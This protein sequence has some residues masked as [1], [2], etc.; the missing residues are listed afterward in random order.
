MRTLGKTTMLRTD[1][2]QPTEELAILKER[3]WTNP[4]VA[5][6]LGMV[7]GSYRRRR[8]KGTL[9]DE[10]RAILRDQVA[11]GI[12]YQRGGAYNP[13]SVINQGVYYIHLQDSPF[14]KIGYTTDLRA[15]M[16]SLQT[17]S[18]GQLNLIAWFPGPPSTEEIHH[19]RWA[20]QHHR[21]E[22]FQR[23]PAMTYLTDTLPFEQDTPPDHDSLASLM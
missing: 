7:E 1:Y 22:W 19:A 6:V 12:T 2:T 5:D 3:G 18:P 20:R 16:S 15:R 14:V 4:H 13:P 11:G 23:V 8:R 9:T 17:G 21:G 10:H